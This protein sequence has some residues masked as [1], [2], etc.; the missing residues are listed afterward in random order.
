MYVPYFGLS[1]LSFLFFQGFIELKVLGYAD[2]LHIAFGRA[3]NKCD[4]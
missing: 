4:Y 1:I 2:S 3:I